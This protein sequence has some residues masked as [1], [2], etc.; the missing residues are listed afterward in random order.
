MPSENFRRH[1]GVIWSVSRVLY[2][3]AIYLGPTLPLGSSHLIRNSR[4]SL[5]PI[6]VLLRIEFTGLHAFTRQP[7]SSYLAFPPLPPELPMHYQA[8][9]NAQ[10]V[11]I[12]MA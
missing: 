7:V 10:K 3:T 2:L 11:D 6:A 4:A 9:S 1:L 5:V 12:V 8:S